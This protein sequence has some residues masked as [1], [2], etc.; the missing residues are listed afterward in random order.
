M[1]TENK[2]EGLLINEENNE[3]KQRFELSRILR[4]ALVSSFILLNITFSADVGVIASSKFKLQ[5][6]LNF[7]DKEFATFNSITSTGRILGTFIYMGLLTRDNRKL[8]T[9]V[10]LLAS[11][12]LFFS[13]LFTSQKFVLFGV[14]FLLGLSR[15]FFQ[16]YVP[17]YVD[18]FGVKPLKTIMISISNITSPLGRALGFAIGTALGEDRWRYSFSVVGLILLSLAVL[19]I[20]SPS[21]FFSAGATFVGYYTKGENNENGRLVKNKEENKRYGDSVFEVGEIKM[22]KKGG[23]D[24]KDLLEILKNPTFMFSTFTRASVSFIFDISHLFIKDYVQKGLGETNQLLLLSYYSI[25]SGFG[26]SVGGFIGGSIVTYF[27]GYENSKSCKVISIFSICTL[28]TTYFLCYTDTLLTFCASLFAFYATAYMFY[29]IITG[30]AVNSLSA[31]QKGTGYS[32][33]ILICTICGNFPGP[34]YYGI[35]NDN[36]KDTNPRLAWRCSIFYYILGFTLLQFACYFRYKDLKKK[37]E[38]IKNDNEEEM[39]DIEN[40]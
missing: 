4:F 34:L 12:G 32:F 28:I 26:P 15:N 17:V 21:R 8:L 29:P 40:K 7:N 38:K 16:I 6:D 20:L 5:K 19:I 1:S 27:G 11:C 2:K 14:R 39:K 31:K 9:S 23:L 18:Q 25:A 35:I 37:E 10:C 30:Y 33:T 3:E 36:F 22:K 24:L 13:F